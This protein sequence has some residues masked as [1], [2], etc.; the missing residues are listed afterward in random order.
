MVWLLIAGSILFLLVLVLV[1]LPIIVKAKINSALRKLD[2]YHGSLHGLRINLFRSVVSAKD[3]K[4]YKA[5]QSTSD[6]KNP[7]LYV[8]TTVIVFKWSQLLKRKLDIHA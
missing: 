2:G 1:L 8:P 4:I 3:L 5:Q 7:F 6:E